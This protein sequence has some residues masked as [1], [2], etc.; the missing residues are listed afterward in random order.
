MQPSLVVLGNTLTAL[1]VARDASSRGL[2]PILVD[3]SWGI[4][5]HTRRAQLDMLDS[6]Q[7]DQ[8]Q[9]AH[10]LELG[11]NKQNY[12]IAT[13][14]SWLRFIVRHRTALDGAFARILH[15]DNEVL[16]ICLNKTRFAQ[17][18]RENDVPSPAAWFPDKETRPA[19]LKLPLFLRPA[20]TLHD[21][22]VPGIPKAVQVTSE[23]DLAGWL[24]RYAEASVEPL[25]TESLL[26]QPLIQYS[27]AVA[28]HG[29]RRL[30]F[31]AEKV[32]PA[33]EACTV[34]TYVRIAEAPAIEASVLNTLEKLGY[35]GIAEV[36]VLYAPR[37]QRHVLIEIN[38]RPW[39]QYALAP[40]I[41]LDFLDVLVGNKPLHSRRQ[42]S[43]AW[44]NWHDD[45]YVCWSRSTGSVRKR[46]IPLLT[47]LRSLL[48]ANVFPIYS[49][50][51]PAPMFARWSKHFGYRP[52]L[53]TSPSS[54][55]SPHEV[56]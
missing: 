8:D 42:A 36:E 1:A 30:S 22:P 18:C 20:D 21:R 24:R 38:A 32:R 15:A 56:V 5:F 34:G 2:N 25:V 28:R 17:W 43:A 46:Q 48:S 14:D 13:G 53:R 23:S 6:S 3:K 47:Y 4:A 7:T 11:A 35:L 12:L 16:E 44:L 29:E 26:G 31:V 27:V 9:L 55:K 45:L 54:T 37:T 33:P 51:D 50:A 39:L 10:I 52:R 19:E 40:A 49:P 41:G